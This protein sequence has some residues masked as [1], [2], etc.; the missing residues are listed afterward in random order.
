MIITDK[1]HFSVSSFNFSLL[2]NSISRNVNRLSLNDFLYYIYVVVGQMKKNAFSC[3]LLKGTVGNSVLSLIVLIFGGS[4]KVLE[5]KCPKWYEMWEALKNDVSFLIGRIR[6]CQ[7][8]N[9]TNPDFKSK[10]D[11]D[12]IP[13]SDLFR[14]CND[15]TNWLRI[16]SNLPMESNSF[17]GL[18]K[19]KSGDN[20]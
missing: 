6:G 20:T 3:S 10:H 1:Q 2:F 13:E 12:F 11:P 16:F 19:G 4:G 14:I 8:S 17:L 7:S 5:E 18:P 9:W 15:V